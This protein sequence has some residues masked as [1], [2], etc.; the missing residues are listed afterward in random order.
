VQYPATKFVD[1]K[2]KETDSHIPGFLLA[3]RL[4]A[5]FSSF[6]HHLRPTAGDPRGGQ[7]MIEFAF[8][9]VIILVLLVGL[10]DLGRAIFTYL[11][12]RDAAQEGASYASYNPADT[13]GIT[14]RVCNSSNMVNDLCINPG[15][16]TDVTVIGNAC[17]GNGIEVQVTYNNF[18]LVTPFLGAIVGSQTIPISA[19]VIDT[20]LTPPCT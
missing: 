10:I 13:T 18:T 9:L 20:I 12:L 1:F 19:S 4:R 5:G 16:D 8:S 11:A 3:S 15:I 2:I 17:S 14:A 6:I 7:S